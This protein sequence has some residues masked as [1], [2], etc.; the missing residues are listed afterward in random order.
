MRLD[1]NAGIKLD[2]LFG[3]IEGRA[4]LIVK[5]NVRTNQHNLAGKQRFK[6]SLTPRAT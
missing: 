5:S 1:L 2:Q 6:L 3:N 4:V